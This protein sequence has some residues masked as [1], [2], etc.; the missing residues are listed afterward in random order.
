MPL[1]VV[2][3]PDF[4]QDRHRAASKLLPALFHRYICSTRLP[5]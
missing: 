4:G 2:N 3:L 5:L 1:P